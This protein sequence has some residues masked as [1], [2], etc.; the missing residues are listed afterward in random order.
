MSSVTKRI[1]E[2]K[3]PRGGYVKPSQFEIHKIDDGHILSET[4]NIH[5]SVVGMA[6]DYLTRFAMGSELLE[7]FK[8]SCMGA[9]MAEELFKQKNAMKKAS[10]L[11]A[12]IK[13]IDEKKGEDILIYEFTQLNPSVDE[14]VIVSGSNQRQ[15]YAIAD[16]VR[17]RLAEHGMRADHIEGNRD[18]HWILIDASDIIVHIFE[19]KER[20]AY[21]L[22]KLYA[23][24]PVS[25]YDV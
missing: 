10:K 7:A 20:T 9:K 12:G 14:V 4:E 24:L 22:E 16:N 1:S 25:R 3:Q 15:T 21:N 23:D 2:I 6:V 8:I 19:Q 17:D 11:L 5:A 18:S 13:A